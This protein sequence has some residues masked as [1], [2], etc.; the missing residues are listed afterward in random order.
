MYT[1]PFSPKQLQFLK[2][3]NAKYN[4]AH[5]SVRSGKTVCT[6]FKFLQAIHACPGESIVIFGYSQGSIY[7]N[8]IS[9]LYNSPE[10]GVFRPFCTWSS[11]GILKFGNRDV[12]CIGAGDE[13]ALGK[14]Q[15]MTI[16]LSYGDEM[17][18]YPD[19]VIDMIQTRHS[20]PHS[21]L[22]AAM[23]PKQPAHK[24]K[25][26][27]DRADDD[28]L[29][30]AL[31]FTLDDNPYLEQSYKDDLKNSLTGLFYKRN[32]LGL[33]CMAEGAIYDFF[34]T[35][36]HVVSR[37]PKCAEYYIAAVDYGTH[38]PFAC[39][40]IGIN[41]G[42]RD[43]TGRKWWVEKEYY[44]DS[45]KQGRQKLNSE[46]ADDVEKFIEPYGV[47]MI[48]VDP[49]AAA[50][51]LE[52]RRRGIHVVDANNDVAY[53]IITVGTEM[54]KGNLTICSECTNLIKEIEGYVWDT[55][56][57]EKG[58]DEPLK[59]S[60]IYDHACD[61]LRY[62]IASHKVSLFDEEAH[63]RKQRKDRT[64]DEWGPYNGQYGK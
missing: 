27:I 37:P 12:F 36:L 60:G 51:K 43:Q 3:A 49:S 63:Y 1:E 54:Y 39:V 10:L 6:L 15:G 35:S 20:R 2:E 47:R 34:D 28:H 8:V 16:D 24:M 4:L 19:N 38:A 18:L 59:G 31:H 46:L 61:A 50:F 53:G 17:T 42:R 25:Q 45:V 7:N 44:W 29:Y 40:L 58:D 57:A 56:K 62:G 14:I 22:F 32:Y 48:Y 64:P 11:K 30:Y 33:W 23:N 52:L 9:L 41:T 21:K 55:K 13:G 26:W 5:G